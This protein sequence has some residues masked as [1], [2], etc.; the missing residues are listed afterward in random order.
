VTDSQLPPSLQEL[1]D[2]QAIREVTMRYCRGVDRG[3]AAMVSSAYHP[4]AFDDHSGHRFSG[5]TVGPGLVEWMKRIT[6][7]STHHITTQTIELDGDTAG[8]ESYYTAFH[9][10][11]ADGAE[12]VTNTVGRYVD[13][14]ERRNGEWK[15]S[16][17]VV[18][19]E[20]ARQFTPFDLG[21]PGGTGVSRRDEGDTSYTV[22]GQSG[23]RDA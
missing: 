12:V 1:L 7:G 22:I 15:I 11:T 14:F 4:D 6:H 3:D 2:K 21:A 23:G 13:R 17:R 20:T 19:L 8:C 16:H 5:E 10:A 9:Y 18:I